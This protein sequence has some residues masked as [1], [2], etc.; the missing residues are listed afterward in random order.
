MSLSEEEVDTSVDRAM[1]ALQEELATRF[2]F[3]KNKAN[4]LMDLAISF[5]NTL[6]PVFLG[7]YENHLDL[8]NIDIAFGLIMMRV[9]ENCT[10]CCQ[11]ADHA[12]I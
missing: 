10:E 8:H 3:N 7:L 2:G 1:R 12:T 6:F 5:R 4:Q 11:E 9:A